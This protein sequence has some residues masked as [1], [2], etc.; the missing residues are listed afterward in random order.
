MPWN[1]QGQIRQGVNTFTPVL[2]V[3]NGSGVPWGVGVGTNG[4]YEVHNGLC[5]ASW[6]VN[7][8]ASMI[9][10]ISSVTGEFIFNLPV[11]PVNYSTFLMSGYWWIDRFW[12]GGGYGNLEITRQYY[13]GS[14]Y[15]K[16]LINRYH[17][18][19]IAILSAPS[20]KD[21]YL[22]SDSAIICSIQYPV[23]T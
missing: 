2:G 20:A 19:P 14:A 16:M 15:A 1:Y 21:T 18:H 9:S 22:W 5:T 23:E 3:S 17:D 4:K 8:D 7:L 12:G 10:I 6:T 13:D 11:N